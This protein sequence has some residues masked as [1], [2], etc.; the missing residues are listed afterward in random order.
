MQAFT[1]CQSLFTSWKFKMIMFTSCEIACYKFKIYDANFTN[2]RHM[3]ESN[4][5]RINLRKLCIILI[6][7][8][9]TID[10]SDIN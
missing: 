9:L 3:L 5:K 2:Y 7:C 10:T 6:K 8:I 1:G 4:F